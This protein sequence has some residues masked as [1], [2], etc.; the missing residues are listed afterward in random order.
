MRA[1]F[2]IP[3]GIHPPENKVQSTATA[4]RSAGIPELLVF[5]LSQHIGAPAKPIVEVGNK[6]LK[7]QMIAEANGFVSVPVHASTSGEVVAIGG[8]VLPHPSGM[9][10]PCISI[11]AD[12]KD[13]WIEHKGVP[14]YEA[15]DRPALLDIIRNAGIAGMGGAGFPSAVK[16]NPRPDQPIKTLIING[17]EC[18]PYITADD[19]LMR[20]RAEQILEGVKVLRHILTPTETVIGI[21]DNKAEALAIMRNA[22]KGTGIEIVDFPTKYPSGG[23]KQLI[24]IITGKEVP[25]GKLPADIGVVVQNLGTATAIYRAVVHGEPLISRITTVTGKA[26][27]Q[28]QNFET[29]LGSPIS[30]LLTLSKWRQD[31]AIRLVMGGPM[32]GFALEDVSIPVVKTTNCI[33]VPNAEELPEPA[34]EQA[35]IRCGMCAEACPASLLPQQ[36]FWFSQGKELEKLQ[37]HNLADCIECGCCSYVCPSNIPL[38]QYYRAS[39]AAIRTHDQ[40]LIKS[41]QSK[42]RFE[43][44]QER[45]EREAEAK[46]AKRQARAEA[47]KK[48]KASAATKPG[49]TTSTTDKDAII[50]AAIARTKAKKSEPSTDP[51]QAAIERAQAKRSGAPTAEETPEAKL[52]KI[53]G[54]LKKAQE[55]YQQAIGQGSD[56]LDAFS[57]GITKL[58]QQLELAK[59]AVPDTS[60]Q[61]VEAST[62]TDSATDAIARAQAQRA[63]GAAKDTPEQAITKLKKRLG[64]A[65]D[66]LATAE[67]ED[68][69]NIEAFRASVSTLQAKLQKAE[70]QLTN[71]NVS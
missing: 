33:L 69:A 34:P 47:A 56:K 65:K 66:K 58:E 70:Q 5:P 1:V 7:G 8:H 44:R 13:Q 25:K 23:E 19:M 14:D 37:Q 30:H 53:E 28:Q 20:E 61:Q 17:T 60:E 48:A 49:E 24:T 27:E 54:R 22:A 3:G 63:G 36:L 64:A 26:A 2:N 29:L 40:D 38:V 11:K 6:V 42:A 12:G 21:E 10:G 15:L 62:N 39:K 67:N 57:A 45:L 46:E 55:K 50:Q 32:M 16:L 18:E 52:V 59:A 43:A 41:D 9:S 35:C 68:N 51:V 31:V 71:D 4:I